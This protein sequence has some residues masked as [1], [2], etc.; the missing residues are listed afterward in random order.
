[1]YP[2]PHTTHMYPPPQVM[3][4]LDHPN[5]IRLYETYR[6]KLPK[7]NQLIPLY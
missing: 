2:P 5:I 7:L 3:K 4:N 1:M 6:S